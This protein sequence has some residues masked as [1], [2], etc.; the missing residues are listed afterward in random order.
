MTP[1]EE[2]FAAGFIKQAEAVQLLKAAAPA[3]ME[4]RGAFK[5]YRESLEKGKRD[6]DASDA[7]TDTTK[8]KGIGAH[9]KR[10]A[11][12]YIGTLGTLGLMAAA[13]RSKNEALLKGVLSIPTA[14]FVGGTFADSARLGKHNYLKANKL[15]ELEAQ[16]KVASTEA[17]TL[18]Q[19]QEYYPEDFSKLLNQH[20]VNSHTVQKN[21]RV[22][23]VPIASTYR[24]VVEAGKGQDWGLL[25]RHAMALMSRG[26]VWGRNNAFFVPKGKNGVVIAAPRLSEDVVKHELGHAEDY[27]NLGGE[28]GWEKE[29]HSAE[30]EDSREHA[31]RSVLLPEA[32]AWHYAGKPVN[33]DPKNPGRVRD[34]AFGSYLQQLGV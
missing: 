2:A 20:A 6:F 13:M 24:E 33:L 15:N 30:P 23:D 8:G 28:K 14:G 29:Y 11:G 26:A 18:K 10:N 16:H 5:R 12:K 1:Q 22:K 25:R 27:A 3:Y 19:L 7:Y 9:F 4:D 21:D 31:M 17:P 34:A 32:R